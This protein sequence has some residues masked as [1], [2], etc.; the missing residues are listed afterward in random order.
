MQTLEIVPVEGQRVKRADSF[1][2]RG[3]SDTL[4]SY[5]YAKLA[6]G[7]VKGF[8]LVYPPARATDMAR[9][10][11]IMQDSFVMRVLRTRDTG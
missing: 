5:T 2:L 8:T 4:E 1:T 10:I 9:V 11:E 3:T 6:R 7:Y